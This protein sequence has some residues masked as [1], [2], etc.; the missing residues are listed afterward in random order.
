MLTHARLFYARLTWQEF[1]QQEFPGRTI[2]GASLCL[3]EFHSSKLGVDSV[4]VAEA[5]DSYKADRA[6]GFCN[7]PHL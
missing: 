5:P 2:W 6:Y 1:T 7:T 4:G 3:G